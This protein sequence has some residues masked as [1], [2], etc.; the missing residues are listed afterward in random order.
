M[1][2]AAMLWAI[3]VLAIWIYKA[4]HD[5]N[6]CGLPKIDETVIML[7]GI[8]FTGKVVQRLGEKPEE[9]T[10]DKPIFKLVEPNTP[11]I[12]KPF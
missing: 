11:P 1:R 2:L 9:T 10:Q 3:G 12:I 6:D 4:L 8:L 5:C 7:L